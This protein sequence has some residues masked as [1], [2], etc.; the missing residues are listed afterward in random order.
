MEFLD[1][2]EHV[3]SP[4]G[5]SLLDL[6]IKQAD[7]EPLDI[8]DA[9]TPEYARFLSVCYWLQQRVGDAPIVLPQVLLSR[10][11]RVGQATISRYI[12]LGQQQGWLQLHRRHN[13][14]R[15]LATRFRFCAGARIQFA[16][17]A[18]NRPRKRVVRRDAR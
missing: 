18:R 13:Q 9:P 16:K 5:Y 12:Q 15:G 1:A 10:K 17:V 6:A 2:W 14:H 3:R 8:Q 4:V 11:L 7:G